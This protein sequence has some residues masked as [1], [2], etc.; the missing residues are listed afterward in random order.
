MAGVAATSM[1]FTRGCGSLDVA[2][3]SDAWAA[4][5]SRRLRIGRM[6]PAKPE[7]SDKRR[8]ETREGRKGDG[9]WLEMKYECDLYEYVPVQASMYFVPK[10]RTSTKYVLFSLSMYL[11]HIGMYCAYNN[12][13]QNAF[14]CRMPVGYDT[15]CR[16]HVCGGAPTLNQCLIGVQHTWHYSGTYWVRT[17][18]YQSVPLYLSSGCT[19]LYSVRTGTY[20]NI[21]STY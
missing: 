9:S 19:G 11:V 17:G 10:V 6:L 16:W 5:Q 12:I 7:A 15:V 2:S 18:M 14:L 1:R 20:R 8:K 21:V 4:W 13:A 3:H